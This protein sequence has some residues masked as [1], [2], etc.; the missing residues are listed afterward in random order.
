MHLE[1]AGFIALGTAFLMVVLAWVSTLF[2]FSAWGKKV[3]PTYW[4]AYADAGV[5]ETQELK[6]IA[7]PRVTFNPVFTAG[8]AKYA[9][10]KAV[11]S[12]RS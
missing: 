4:G 2:R 10:G 9:A 3:G 11:K 6:T 8:S 1:I 12:A 7:L 5:A